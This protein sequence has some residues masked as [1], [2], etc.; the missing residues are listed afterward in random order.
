MSQHNITKR[1]WE[2]YRAAE[3]KSGRKFTAADRKGKNS[4]WGKAMRKAYDDI[5][6]ER[7]IA[8]VQH[9]LLPVPKYDRY[10]LDPIESSEGRLRQYNE[11]VER[12]MRIIAEASER[13][14]NQ[15]QAAEAKAFGLTAHDY[16]NTKKWADANNMSVTEWMNH[17][18]IKD[19]AAK[20][21][22]RHETLAWISSE[23]KRKVAAI[24]NRYARRRY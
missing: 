7:R 5:M 14:L 22:D 16:R 2:I 20:E 3:V 11:A 1:A 24:H 10:S 4:E 18:K 13:P 21:K 23:N 8:A 12:N 17:I 6:R 9:L 19:E 15:K